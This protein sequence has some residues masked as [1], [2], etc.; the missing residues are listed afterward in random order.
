MKK[1]IQAFD[2]VNALV[3]CLVGFCAFFPVWYVFVIS[4]STGPGYIKDRLHFWPQGIDFS[5]YKRVLA[6][7]D[8]MH[9]LGNSAFITGTGTA[10]A[11]LIT[12]M[13]A[14]ALSRKRLRGRKIVTPFI[15]FTMFFSAG[16]I[17]YYLLVTSLHLKN[18]FWALILPSLMN[19]YYMMIMRTYFAGITDSLEESAKI[20][21]AS[22]FRILFT[23]MIPISTPMIAAIGLFFGVQYY[24]DYFNAL[25]FITSRNL[26]PLQ[27]LL[28]EMVVNN[29][30]NS[31][32][33]GGSSTTTGDIFKM[34]SVILSI[35]PILMVYPFLQKY[36]VQGLMLGSVKE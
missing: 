21:G 6:A 10:L 12:V 1:R 26:Y 32:S 23:L 13:A 2:V 18:T 14:Y 28:R 16:L 15:L 11:L 27:F 19:A 22:D 4:V 5:E 9:S 30:A 20:D 17:P 24:N 29:I 8:L 35:I 25:L 36:F 3:M 34:A 33:V 7:G 31:S